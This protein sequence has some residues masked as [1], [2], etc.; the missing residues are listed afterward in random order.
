[1]T[2]VSIHMPENTGLTG[3]TLYLR[4]TSDGTLVNTGGDSMTESPASSGRFT[5]TVSEA[6][7]ETLAVVVLD[8]NSLAVRD[9]WLASGETIIKD[10]YPATTGVLE[11]IAK[12]P[13]EGETR[14]YTQVAASA[15]DRTADVTIGA[16]L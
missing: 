6:W 1:M 10:S 7:T 3:F 14:R 13:K 8:S 5:A 12:I 15:D 16:S 11:E 9:G 4:K 2:T